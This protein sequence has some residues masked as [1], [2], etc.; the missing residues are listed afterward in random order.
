MRSH[1]LAMQE[2]SV[3][4]TRVCQRKL[5]LLL[6]GFSWPSQRYKDANSYWNFW[7]LFARFVT[8]SC[9]FDFVYDSII[10]DLG[11]PTINKEKGSLYKLSRTWLIFWHF[12]KMPKGTEGYLQLAFSQWEPQYVFSPEEV[13]ISVLWQYWCACRTI[14]PTGLLELHHVIW[15][16][17]VGSLHL[18][19]FQQN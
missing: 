12:L 16:L 17:E 1:S 3:E 15:A 19:E 2:P 11:E 18:L 10:E 6:M 4:A 13:L 5:G 14:G 9:W 8:V 7:Y